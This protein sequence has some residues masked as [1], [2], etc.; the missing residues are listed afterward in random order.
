LIKEEQIKS[1]LKN[2]G[3]ARHKIISELLTRFSLIN[4]YGKA[5]TGKTTYATQLLRYFLLSSERNDQYCIWVQASE[6]FSKQRLISMYKDKKSTLQYIQN[7]IL[8]IPQKHCR[9][10]FQLT[11]VLTKLSNTSIEIPPKTRVMII[12]NISHH[13]RFEIS[14]YSDINLIT[15]ILDDFFDSVLLPLL[16]FCGRNNILL[17]LIH[18]VTYNPKQEKTTMFNHHLFEN[19]QSLNIELKKDLFSNQRQLNFH[20]YNTSQSFNVDLSEKGIIFES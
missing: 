16:F 13:L 11:N 20:Y 19:L 10:Y 18:E 5:G 4:I 8:V 2:K 9:D 6:N 12:D 17:I 1:I 3:I 14:H 15:T 7:H